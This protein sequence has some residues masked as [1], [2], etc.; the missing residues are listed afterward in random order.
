M[1][2]SRIL[3][4]NTMSSI[5]I[6][7]LGLLAFSSAA[8]SLPPITIPD[9]DVEEVKDLVEKESVKIPVKNE[10]GVYELVEVIYDKHGGTQTITIPGQGD[11]TIITDKDGNYDLTITPD[12]LKGSDNMKC[13]LSPLSKNTKCTVTPLYVVD[14]GT[15]YSADSAEFSYVEGEEVSKLDVTSNNL[16]ITDKDEQTEIKKNQTDL[17]VA[18]ISLN[19]KG[20]N[21][22]GFLLGAIPGIESDDSDPNGLES[23]SVS[24]S[25]STLIHTVT[26]PNNPKDE[27]VKLEIP[28]GVETTI[29][30]AQDEQGNISVT[31]SG[32]LNG[33]L[34][35]DSDPFSDEKILATSNSSTEYNL[36]FVEAGKNSRG[37]LVLSI[38]ESNS[39]GEKSL[40][41]I[42]DTSDK[43]IKNTVTTSGATSVII[44]QEFDSTGEN[45]GLGDTNFAVASESLNVVN[46]E[47]GVTKKFG[48]TNSDISGS[49]NSN[50]KT[51]NVAFK[52]DTM[53]VSDDEDD[54]FDL[55]LFGNINAYAVANDEAKTAVVNADHVVF[56]NDD[57]NV[58]TDGNVTISYKNKNDPKDKLLGKDV[59]QEL[60][61][62][63]DNITFEDEDTKATIGGGQFYQAALKD[64]STFQVASAQT[65]NLVGKDATVQFNDG[66]KFIRSY[67]KENEV[68]SSQLIS[69]S[70]AGTYK[71]KDTYSVQ[72]SSTF[73]VTSKN[74]KGEDL[75]TILHSNSSV[76]IN[77]DD[78][79]LNVKGSQL[80]TSYTDD[81]RVGQMTFDKADYTK[82]L[83]EKVT[84]KNGTVLFYTDES[85]PEKEHKEGSFIASD[86]NLKN[87]DIALDITA[88]GKDGK[89]E[90]FTI[91]YLE[92]GT[93]TIVQVY[94]EDGGLVKLD[95]VGK[96][97]NFGDILFKTAQYYKNEEFSSFAVAEASGNIKKL[98]SDSEIVGDFSAAKISGYQTND[99][100]FSQYMFEDGKLSLNN[101]TDKYS[102]DLAVESGVFQEDNT[103]VVKT[104][105]AHLE[106][107]VFTGESTDSSKSDL[108]SLA[109]FDS[110]NIFQQSTT[111]GNK[112]TALQA[113]KLYLS[114]Q[115]TQENVQGSLETGQMDL[116]QSK[117]ESSISL[118]PGSALRLNSTKDNDAIS[119]TMIGFDAYGIQ[120]GSIKYGLI[121]FDEIAID[122]KK[123]GSKEIDQRVKLID[124]SMMFYET[125]EDDLFNREA[126]LT[127]TSIEASNA[128]YQLNISAIGE[129]GTPG[130]FTMFFLEENG[131]RSVR[132]FDESGK[133]V[134]LSGKDKDGNFGDVLFRTADY[135]ENEKFKQFLVTEF[136]SSVDVNE[137]ETGREGAVLNFNAARIG[138]QE[139]NDGSYRNVFADDISISHLDKKSK[140]Q[141]SVNVGNAS[142]T[143]TNYLGTI[144]QNIQAYDA[145]INYAEYNK[146]DAQLNFGSLV[147]SNI[148]NPDGKKLSYLKV[149][150]MNFLATDYDNMAKISGD[151]GELSY[152]DSDEMT[153]VDIKDLNKL[154][155][156]SL[157]R[158]IDAV[159]KGKRFLKVD[160][161]N[162]E[163][164]VTSS[165]L[166]I[167]D[168]SGEINAKEDNITAKVNLNARVFE[169]VR[170]EVTGKN[171]ILRADADFK[172]VASYKTGLGNIKAK[173]SGAIKGEN[174]TTSSSSYESEDG[175]VRGGKLTIHADKLEKL[176]F[177]TKVGFLDLAEFKAVGKNGQS[178][179]YSYEIDKSQGVIK[180][181]GVYKNGDKLETKFLFF[182][183]KSHKEGNDAVSALKI[184]L[185]GQSY[186]DHLAIMSETASIRQV[187]DFFGVS[188]GGA[189]T[190]TAGAKDKGFAMELMVVNDKFAFRAPDT[191]KTFHKPTNS[192]GLAIKYI[193]EEDNVWGVQTALTSDSRIEFE[194]DLR[195]FGT[196][197]ESIPTTANLNLTYTNKDRD[198]SVVGGVHM[199]LTTSLVDKDLLDPDAQFFDGGSRKASGPG[200]HL[201]VTKKFENSELRFTGGMY[202]NFSEPAFHVSYQG[203]P[204]VLANIGKGI[205]NIASGEPYDTGIKRSG[206]GPSKYERQKRRQKFIKDEEIRELESKRMTVLEKRVDNLIKHYADKPGFHKIKEILKI[207]KNYL[208]SPPKYNDTRKDIFRYTVKDR[209]EFIFHE[210]EKG[211][212]E[213]VDSVVLGII[214][215]RILVQLPFDER[216]RK[217]MLDIY[218]KRRYYENLE[219][220]DELALINKSGLN[221]CEYYMQNHTDY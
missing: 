202:D 55:N 4:K 111:D 105:T 64:G 17:G 52:A 67:D 192:Y 190:F 74:D 170:D 78:Q 152:F 61:A 45:R 138:G 23:I 87:K 36:S 194:G 65:G 100:K 179:S 136:K 131:D 99:K 84:I 156:N 104:T 182:K 41:Q 115:S 141:I 118:A 154:E 162:D 83:D 10:E 59:N 15:T 186:Q 22:D 172:A 44:D 150:D 208:N 11:I 198:L 96:D 137:F 178:I 93:E 95:G 42:T 106:N 86:I 72:D 66:A 122:K 50:T 205:I 5:A 30:T 16:L 54:G 28:G 38:P 8:Q 196:K 176:E 135:Y 160:T 204:Q 25:A 221:P 132:V 181:R 112:T 187:N 209:A 114:G 175:R 213:A 130:K 71:E 200:A 113:Q 81:I 148:E 43:G 19:V 134:N 218:R 49:V 14:K 62:K 164:D 149:K 143:E 133:L 155:L 35:Y 210:P 211:M 97:E 109:T 75:T 219:S 197:V 142:F 159:F 169:F 47:D 108:S 161:K 92:K 107:G 24:A 34:K 201:A 215:N 90:N 129:D 89:K 21:K 70:L 220:L 193:T 13:S 57:I 76:D 98:S 20:K 147:A 58:N 53:S 73:L 39:A 144:S 18:S 171:T 146:V 40:L 9:V 124:G 153:V 110:L 177:K 127:S 56:S 103:G 32:K 128:D 48:L 151:V 158:D 191:F 212:V 51:G 173:V 1:F 102:G 85:N 60:Y 184:K 126:K 94:G 174:I 214:E 37:T 2:S 140:A 203:S 183:L 139:L 206:S 12:E 69:S 6:T 27:R 217:G 216:E 168:G 116:F 91:Y 77:R 195:A 26:N 3:L 180:L 125:E 79:D 163:G 82:G 31:S 29:Q 157:D 119:A 121:N 46:E 7:I 123:T 120:K 68:L 101:V 80:H 33:P 189:I 166:L 188:D 88:I 165:Y 117:D 167:K 207:A 185:K 63:A 145:T 199:P